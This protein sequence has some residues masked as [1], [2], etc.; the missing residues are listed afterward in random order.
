MFSFIKNYIIYILAA[1]IF[2]QATYFYFAE[3]KLESKNISL[4]QNIEE[5][6]KELFICKE[7][8]KIEV[9]EERFKNLEPKEEEDY[10]YEIIENDVNFS[11][12][13]FFRL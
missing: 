4:K 12:I 1:V 3:K 8:K 13:Q 11:T 2:S 7:N 5:Q 9:F 10:D 6:K